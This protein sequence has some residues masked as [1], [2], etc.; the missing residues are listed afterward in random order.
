MFHGV[1]LL[2]FL[3][4]TLQLVGSETYDQAYMQAHM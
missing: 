1:A 3:C 4:E 2:D